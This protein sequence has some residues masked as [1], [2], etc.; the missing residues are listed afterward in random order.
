MSRAAPVNQQLPPARLCQATG[1]SPFTTEFSVK[2]PECPRP[3]VHLA[4]YSGYCP[5][6]RT[7]PSAL[8]CLYSKP[9]L[10]AH[11][12]RASHITAMLKTRI[13]APAL[14]PALLASNPCCLLHTL[15]S[16][17][18]SQSEFNLSNGIFPQTSSLSYS[19]ITAKEKKY[20]EV[21]FDSFS[22]FTLKIL[23]P[24]NLSFRS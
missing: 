16:T 11:T 8:F 7:W 13:Y 17:A 6:L 4:H 21:I 15:F 10:G 2:C 24:A 18:L 14:S 3:S 22:S 20:P 19:C 5:E 9:L 23:I 12:P 1:S